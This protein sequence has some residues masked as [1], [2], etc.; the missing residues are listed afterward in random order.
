MTLGLQQAVV[1]VVCTGAALFAAW[2]L[3]SA[4]L[5]LAL[6]EILAARVSAGSGIG[7][8]LADRLSRQ[9]IAAQGSGCSTCGKKP[10]VI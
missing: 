7:H 6:L 9:R 1:F 8:W 3:M 5:R 10:P 4:R 2:R